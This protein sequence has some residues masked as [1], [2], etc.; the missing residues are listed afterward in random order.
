MEKYE[1]LPKQSQFLMRLLVLTF[2]VRSADRGKTSNKKKANPFVKNKTTHS[3]YNTDLASTVFKRLKLTVPPSI[4][5]INLQ[6]TIAPTTVPISF[7]GAIMLL[8]QLWLRMRAFGLGLI[9]TLD[10][11]RNQAIFTKCFLY[12]CEARLVYAQI[13]SQNS[14]V[15]DL[16]S[17]NQF[18][19]LQL[20]IIRNLSRI[21]PYPLVMYLESIGNFIIDNQP[22]VPV[23]ATSALAAHSGAYS[24]APTA[25][26]TFLNLF[27]DAV[28]VTDEILQLVQLIDE[29]P[30]INWVGPNGQ[31]WRMPN[32]LQD[33][34]NQPAITI[35]LETIRFWND[36]IP[37]DADRRIFSKIVS[38]MDPVPGFNLHCDIA[39]GEGSCVQ[40]IRFP[41]RHVTNDT[42]Y[43]LNSI[44]P[45]FEEQI[46]PAFVLGFEF[47]IQKISRFC[48]TYTSCLKHGSASA[49]KAV[50]A[51]V[52]SEQR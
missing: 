49:P 50:N 17:I 22:V 16:P 46:A 40:I 20:R 25:I 4:S 38:S 5:A 26:N 51:V 39:T 3:D 9:A 23:L 45:S 18:T 11:Q 21:L 28:P 52:W 10:T 24:K 41:E 1:C 6:S 27:V 33:E 47:G 31:P 37:S 14:S 30:G 32:P 12:I 7:F 2:M 29:L 48:D 43:Y 8:Q 44:V 15:L 42:R 19:E 13:A 35:S 34:Q 36:E